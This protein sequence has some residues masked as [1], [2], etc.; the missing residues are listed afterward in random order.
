MSSPLLI[1]AALNKTVGLGAISIKLGQSTKLDFTMNP[2]DEDQLESALGGLKRPWKYSWVET[3]D[4]GLELIREQPEWRQAEILL[5]DLPTIR[6]GRLQEGSR[7]GRDDLP[8]L[9]RA[10]ELKSVGREDTSP[11]IIIGIFADDA[12]GIEM[13]SAGCN[14]ICPLE[15]LAET[16]KEQ[17]AFSERKFTWK[18]KSS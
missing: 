10:H 18:R 13:L 12:E 1:I 5:I 3:I 6:A 2:I 4:Q 17:L 14:L 8:P 15:E 11:R 16:I 7:A 9:K